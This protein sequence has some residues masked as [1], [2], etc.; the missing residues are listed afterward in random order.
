M[1]HISFS[2]LLVQLLFHMRTVRVCVTTALV[3]YLL[4]ILALYGSNRN[5]D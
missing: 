1:D 4:F 2:V 3:C 5:G